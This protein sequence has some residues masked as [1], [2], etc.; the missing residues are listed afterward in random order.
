MIGRIVH[1]GH[2]PHEKCRQPFDMYLKP[3]K[4][5]YMAVACNVVFDLNSKKEEK[6]ERF[7]LSIVD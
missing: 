3:L 7:A 2:R 1:L 5:F 6:K 4:R